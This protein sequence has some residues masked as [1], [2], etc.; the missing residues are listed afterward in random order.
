M[1][2]ALFRQK[3]ALVWPEQLLLLLDGSGMRKRAEVHVNRI[4]LLRRAATAC[5]ALTVIINAGE[6][7]L[8]LQYTFAAVDVAICS[9]KCLYGPHLAPARRNGQLWQPSSSCT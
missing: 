7:C 9:S 3:I 5:E 4:L 1:R 8:L 6:T 2:P